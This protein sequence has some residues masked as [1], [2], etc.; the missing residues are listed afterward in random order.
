M[1]SLLRRVLDG[2]RPADPDVRLDDIAFAAG[3]H[4]YALELRPDGTYRTLVTTEL[5]AMLRPFPPGRL[6]R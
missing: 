3:L 5:R 1:R 6:G 4:L 2:R